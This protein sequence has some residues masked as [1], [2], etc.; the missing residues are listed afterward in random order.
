MF[1]LWNAMVTGSNS[2][3]SGIEHDWYLN[4]ET[5]LY[6]EVI[7]VACVIVNET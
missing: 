6:S 7:Q 5:S 1:G 4:A 2:N 3:S